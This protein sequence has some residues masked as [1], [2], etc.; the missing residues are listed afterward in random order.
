VFQGNFV[1]GHLVPPHPG[2]AMGKIVKR[3]RVLVHLLF[4]VHIKSGLGLSFLVF[5]FCCSFDILARLL[6]QCPG[7]F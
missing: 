5:A 1:T 4:F 7:R 2:P 6:W 3:G